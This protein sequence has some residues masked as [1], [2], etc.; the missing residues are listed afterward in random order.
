MC[1]DPLRI[2]Q[3]LRLGSAAPREPRKLS[4]EGGTPQE[5]FWREF[6][7]R[8]KLSSHG[9]ISIFAMVWRGNEPLGNFKLHDEMCGFGMSC[10][11]K[12]AMK[13]RRSNVVG[14]IS[15][16]AEWFPACKFGKIGSST[17]D[18]TIVD[19]WPPSGPF[20]KSVRRVAHRVQSQLRRDARSARKSVI[21]PW[22]APISIHVS[23]ARM[24][25]HS[26][27]RFRHAEIAEK[28]L[29]QMERETWRKS[30]NFSARALERLKIPAGRARNRWS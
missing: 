7:A 8:I 12:D 3:R 21:S 4:A 6:Q 19:V 5:E 16:K 25:E 22:P 24:R 13:N 17:S 29:S 30:N 2:N 23:P 9:K 14:N 1:W 10:N 26:A 27:M 20:T 18:S 11:S 28:V 15:V